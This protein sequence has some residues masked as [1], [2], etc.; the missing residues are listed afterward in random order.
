MTTAIPHNTNIDNI[1]EG[2]L[3]ESFSNAFG[4]VISLWHNG[5]E[6]EFSYSFRVQRFTFKEVRDGIVKLHR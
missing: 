1:K 6:V 5:I 2:D 3:V 4:R